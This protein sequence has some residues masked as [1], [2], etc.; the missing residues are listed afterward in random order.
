MTTMHCLLGKQHQA[1]LLGALVLLHTV[2]H[3]QDMR[4]VAAPLLVFM[5]LFMSEVTIKMWSSATDAISRW[6]L[7]AAMRIAW[8]FRFLTF[9][10]RFC[11]A[12]TCCSTHAMAVVLGAM[13]VG[14]TA[15]RWA[16]LV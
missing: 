16:E 6:T 9:W 4:L 8:P 1:V 10:A 2:H 5:L 7:R 12:N 15:R 3:A 11:N 13:V 14:V